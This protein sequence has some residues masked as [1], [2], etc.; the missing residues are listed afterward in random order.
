MKAAKDNN[1]RLKQEKEDRK[2]KK[3][4]GGM[5]LYIIGIPNEKTRIGIQT[6]IKNI[7]EDHFP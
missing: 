6:I 5:N 3:M 4:K 7:T 2:E 1:Q